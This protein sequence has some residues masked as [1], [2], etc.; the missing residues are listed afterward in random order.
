MLSVSATVSKESLERCKRELLE[1]L[2][3]KQ[4]EI[5]IKV[6]N[7]IVSGSVDYSPGPNNGMPAKVPQ[8]SGAF[9]ASWRI[10]SGSVDN[11]SAVAP[12]GVR[13]ARPIFPRA[14]IVANISHQSFKVPIYISNS[15]VNDRGEHYAEDIENRGTP[16]HMEGWKI[17]YN[18]TQV[19]RLLKDMIV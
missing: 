1:K 14:S 12:T 18:A 5:A 15:V 11:S 19:A 9:M 8:W 4:E 16:K 6:Y 2:T 13:I 17:A 3:R 10:E 7:F